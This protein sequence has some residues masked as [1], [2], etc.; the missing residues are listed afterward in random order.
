MS[1]LDGIKPTHRSGLL[2][3]EIQVEGEW[4]S[5][6][7]ASKQSVIE[8]TDLLDE[9]SDKDLGESWGPVL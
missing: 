5:M 8:L 9:L 3:V 7:L 1:K 4:I 6:A 2:K